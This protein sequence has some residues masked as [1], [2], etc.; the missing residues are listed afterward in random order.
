MTTAGYVFMAGA[1]IGICGLTIF[2]Y[3]KI[4]FDK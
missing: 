3:K 4:L 2:C 1:W